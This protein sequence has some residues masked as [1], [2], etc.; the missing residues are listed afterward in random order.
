[1]MLMM[2]L[3]SKYV[4]IN[5]LIAD[6]LIKYFLSTKYEKTNGLPSFYIISIHE[7]QGFKWFL[8]NIFAISKM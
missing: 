2:L 6:I 1:M 5:P 7:K 8:R 3:T 4:L